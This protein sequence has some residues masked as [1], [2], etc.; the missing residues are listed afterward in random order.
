MYNELKTSFKL[1]VMVICISMFSFQFYQAMLNLIAPPTLDSSF[2]KRITEIEPPIITIC[3][4][5]QTV[6]SKMKQLKYSQKGAMFKGKANCKNDSCLSWGHHLNLTFDQLVEQI[7]N[8]KLLENIYFSPGGFIENIVILPRFGFCKEIS[9]YNP[10]KEIK[11][12]NKNPFTDVRI[13]LTDKK[14][15]SYYSL[16]FASH[17]GSS[18]ITQHGKVLCINVE[19]HIY[20]SCNILEDSLDKGDFQT[21]VN[22]KLEEDLLPIIGCVPPLMSPFNQ[23]NVSYPNNAN[24]NDKFLKTYKKV[25]WLQ[26]SKYEDECKSCENMH[27]HVSIRDEINKAETWEGNNQM[28][29]AVKIHFD[30]TVYITEKQFNYDLFKFIIDIGSSLGLWLGL[31][32]LGL[33]DIL[34]QFIE[35]TKQVNI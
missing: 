35:V 20:S 14:H 21:C 5:N 24:F 26:Q 22:S 19:V 7:F 15:R 12:T 2:E 3:P 17:Q 4:T 9:S 11:I 28:P 30:K 13:F 34:V 25:N 1:V 32:V 6:F 31:S 10:T 29:F 16:D 33:Y 23:C 8:K 18:I 27:L